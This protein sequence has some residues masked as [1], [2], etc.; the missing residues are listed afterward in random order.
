VWAVVQ[1]ATMERENEALSS[2]LRAQKGRSSMAMVV[3]PPTGNTTTFMAGATREISKGTGP[4]TIE[5]R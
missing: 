1:I 3:L 5:E 2:G 4:R